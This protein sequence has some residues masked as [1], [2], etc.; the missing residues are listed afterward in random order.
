MKNT[1]KELFSMVY[2]MAQSRVRSFVFTVNN[3]SEQTIIELKAVKGYQ[4]IVLGK[5]VAPT[6]GTPHLQSF[7]YFK[8]AKTLSSVIKLLNK[9]CPS[10]K[11]IHVE[12]TMGT[13]QQAIDYCKKDKPAS[14]IIEY[15][16]QPVDKSVNL[17]QNKSKS[18]IAD[19]KE[20]KQ[21]KQIVE[22]N[23]GLYLRYGK[24]IEKL[25][26]MYRPKPNNQLIELRP[27]QQQLEIILNG[28]T[29]DRTIHWVYDPVGNNGKTKLSNH[30]VSSNGYI[31]LTNG[32]T[33]D[34]AYAWNGENVIFDYS[35][36]QEDSINYGIIE[37]I[38]NGS[39]F[40]TKY[41]SISKSYKSPVVC[42][43][44]NFLPNLNK[45]SIDRWQIYTIKENH[46]VD[47]TS[48]TINGNIIPSEDEDNE[49]IHT[50]ITQ[51]SGGSTYY[52]SVN[53]TSYNKEQ[54]RKYVYDNASKR[55]AEY[56]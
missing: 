52:H 35:R 36:S 29:S 20:G 27:W 24:N 14:D 43:M 17:A 13:N 10:V 4:Y 37:D 56:D 45:M 34:I 41:N 54:Y 22:D 47:I 7:I 50:T 19:I 12:Q 30:M 16:N 44:A 21:L 42:I 31:R 32:K 40:S 25:Y 2:Y 39:V 9:S 46:L 5:E 28:D 53:G 33:A 11:H 51:S 26:D 55:L 38:K 8:E 15:G 18:I 3:Y 6:T 49:S 1:F 23:E 48:E